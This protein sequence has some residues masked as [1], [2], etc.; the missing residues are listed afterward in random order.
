M[1][2]RILTYAYQQIDIDG[3]G[4]RER[5]KTENDIVLCCM[6]LTDLAT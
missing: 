3:Q 1:I 4:E 6:L 5:E 2:C